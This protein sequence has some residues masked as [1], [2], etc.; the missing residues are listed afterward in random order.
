MSERYTRELRGD[1]YYV[2]TN[3]LSG[4]S[5]EAALTRAAHC[6]RLGFD[7]RV[8]LRQRRKGLFGS[9]TVADLEVRSAHLTAWVAKR[10]TSLAGQDALLAPLAG[11]FG[12]GVDHHEQ[13]A[14]RAVG[15]NMHHQLGN[16]VA[17][18]CGFV[19]ELVRY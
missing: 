15:V 2:T 6:A 18:V 19:P 14:N 5:Q 3:V 8:A 11:L 1:V 9:E 4:W 12:G 7:A 16:I 17:Y 10:D 13:A